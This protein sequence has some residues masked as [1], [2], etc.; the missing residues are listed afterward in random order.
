MRPRMAFFW[1]LKHN[2]GIL[3]SEFG[4]ARSCV[5]HTTVSKE[6]CMKS[7]KKKAGLALALAAVFGLSAGS[8]LAAAVNVN[9]VTAWNTA[10]SGNTIT[11]NDLTITGK[12]DAANGIA[13]SGG[14]L[15]TGKLIL[16]DTAAAAGDLGFGASNA[17]TFTGGKI[18][19]DQITIK[20][21]TRN[22]LDLSQGKGISG[23]QTLTGLPALTLHIGGAASTA[24]NSI[25]AK[26]LNYYSTQ[27]WQLTNTTINIADQ[28]TFNW[29]P[30]DVST[31]YQGTSLMAYN[32]GA[33]TTLNSK[34]VMTGGTLNM[35]ASQK[36]GYGR[37]IELNSVDIRGGIVN[38]GGYYQ[39]GSNNKFTS[40]LFGDMGETGDHFT[41]GGNA[42]INLHDWGTIATCYDDANSGLD[43]AM[44]IT[45][46]AINM[47]GSSAAK[48]S[49]IRAAG[50]SGKTSS[51]TDHSYAKLN[52]S[53]GEINVGAGKYGAIL[54]RE[55]HMTGGSI[56]V[57]GSL[58]VAGAYSWQY[59]VDTAADIAAATKKWGDFYFDGGT[60]NIGKTGLVDF[61]TGELNLHANGGTLN[62]NLALASTM[63]A[64]TNAVKGTLYAKKVT[65]DAGK[66]MSVAVLDV[67]DAV[68][69]ALKVTGSLAVTGKTTFDTTSPAKSLVIDATGAVTAN[70]GDF[71]TTAYEAKANAAETI[72]AASGATLYLRG[73][74]E[75][76]TEANVTAAKTALGNTATVA[77]LDGTVMDGGTPK[78]ITA[79][80][81]GSSITAPTT[82]TPNND[83]KAQPVDSA[84]ATVS[85]TLVSNSLTV[86]RT[87]ASATVDTVKV[88]TATLTGAATGSADAKLI[89]DG[90]VSTN[91]PAVEVSK[92]LNLGIAGNDNPQGGT[93]GNIKLAASSGTAQLNVNDGAFKTGAITANGHSGVRIGFDQRSH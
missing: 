16:G 46:G 20:G 58:T 68:V 42:V 63:P 90:K 1:L 84:T 17:L 18:V 65:V 33:T 74:P 60:I 12:I 89:K 79:T 34:L 31:A 24:E 78:E 87:T 48:A 36:A 72:N 54:S 29:I 67:S 57:D 25:S 80:T 85:G 8:A 69:D 70:F 77:F 28:G 61:V 91:T 2:P 26:E 75:A 64:G 83:V 6:K 41:I 13:M 88:E 23:S 30:S 11:T 52:I 37:L 47:L 7:S 45:G 38:I 43:F 71:L 44:D 14:S 59:A 62:G 73:N 35:D 56:N 92:S 86:A 22:L 53:D 40:T 32:D 5:E 49:I 66:T 76:Y 82:P 19:A 15:T 50:L 3:G 93:V 81:S 9:D 10:T 39:D 21:T 55:T 51:D 27:G 4:Q